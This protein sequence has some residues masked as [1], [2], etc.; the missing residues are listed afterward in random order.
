MV[1]PEIKLMDVVINGKRQCANGAAWKKAK[2]VA[3]ACGTG[4]NTAVENIAVVKMK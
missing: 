4:S 3:D 1:S 2:P